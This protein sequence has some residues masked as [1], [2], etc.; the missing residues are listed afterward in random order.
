MI[1]YERKIQSMRIDLKKLFAGEAESLLVEDSFSMAGEEVSGAYPF[2]TPVQV[3]ARFTARSGAVQLEA[4]VDYLYRMNCDRCAEETERQRHHTFRHML[5]RSLNEEGND[6]YIEVGD[7]PLD[8]EE[9]LH[10]DIVLEIPS[11][12]V[13]REDCKGLCPTCGANLNRVS[14]D[15]QRRQTDPRLEIL[16]TLID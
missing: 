15:C 3:K 13:C 12:F 6:D 16:K 8:L 4:D 14:C 5:V 1:V 2:V 7:E 10:A 11:K 9:L